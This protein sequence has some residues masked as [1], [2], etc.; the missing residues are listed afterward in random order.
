MKIYTSCIDLE[1]CLD[2]DL[3]ILNYAAVQIGIPPGQHALKV[4]AITARSIENTNAPKSVS[5]TV[6]KQRCLISEFNK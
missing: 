1:K 5:G 6:L 3:L 4:C 2:N